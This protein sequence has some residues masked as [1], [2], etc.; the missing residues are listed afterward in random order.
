MKRC[1]LPIKNVGETLTGDSD[2]PLHENRPTLT[3][4]YAMMG[5]NGTFE[6]RQSGRAAL[7]EA[8]S[9]LVRY[10]RS[11]WEDASVT[12]GR[13]EVIR[14]DV[15]ALGKELQ[16]ENLAVAHLLPAHSNNN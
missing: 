4:P 3:A 16:L 8:S 2:K 14:S 13:H 9:A 12:Q 1:Y 7:T 11:Q 10:R 5:N 15:S 6:E